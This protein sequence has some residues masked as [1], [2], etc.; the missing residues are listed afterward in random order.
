[1]A[2]DR[3]FQTPAEKQR[4]YRER[5]R[6]VVDPDLPEVDV[7][8]AAE[9]LGSRPLAALLRLAPADALSESEEQVLRDHFGYAA[10]E[11]RTRAEREQAARRIT[12]KDPGVSLEE[13]VARNVAVARA[14]MVLPRD[15]AA[16]DF[17]EYAAA[18]LK[19]VERYARWRYAG[20]LDG[21]VG[22]L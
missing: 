6:E 4:A 2:R 7:S 18:S 19:N 3:Q 10:S 1:V 20:V 12:G 13:Y 17:D 5:K 9:P 8:G 14:Q 22:T 16:E 11:T 15:V 21:S